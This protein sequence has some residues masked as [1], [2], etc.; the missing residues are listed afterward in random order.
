MVVHEYRKE[1][2]K[3]FFIETKRV[4]EKARLKEKLN[5]PLEQQP[6]ESFE[7]DEHNMFSHLGPMEPEGQWGSQALQW[8][9]E[10]P[11][12]FAKVFPSTHSPLTW[13]NGNKTKC[14]YCSPTNINAATEDSDLERYDPKERLGLRKYCPLCSSSLLSETER[15]EKQAGLGPKRSRSRSLSPS[16]FPETQIDFQLNQVEQVNLITLFVSKSKS[17]PKLNSNGNSIHDSM[18]TDVNNTQAPQ[19]TQNLPSSSSQSSKKMKTL[20][21]SNGHPIT[22]F[23]IIKENLNP[24]GSLQST[25][26]N[27]SNLEAKSESKTTIF[28]P[29]QWEEVSKN[30]KGIPKKPSHQTPSSF[31]IIS[32]LKK[33]Q[34]ETPTNSYP[35]E[36]DDDLFDEKDISKFSPGILLNTS[37]NSPDILLSDGSSPNSVPKSHSISPNASLGEKFS[38]IAFRKQ[39]IDPTATP[40]KSLITTALVSKKSTDK[41][42]KDNNNN[43]NTSSLNSSPILS[44]QQGAHTTTTTTSRWFKIKE[45]SPQKPTPPQEKQQQQRDSK[46][47]TPTSNKSELSEIEKQEQE[48]EQELK[49]VEEFQ[50]QENL[51]GL[52]I[53]ANERKSFIEFCRSFTDPFNKLKVW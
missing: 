44:S 14:P 28:S 30:M 43:N 9:F 45:K 1:D 6:Q 48:Q 15:K 21:N 36:Q 42:D 2:L 23:I 24:S 53:K 33:I 46:Q 3:E 13:P 19:T 16:N 26:S 38:R 49:G 4:G 41:D 8:Y 40:D 32:A 18:E 35:L 29:N 12:Y 10:Q 20:K 25:I 5:S 11:R 17:T 47:S 52:S 37:G 27:Y 31:S 7:H 22:E 39:T 34:D 50:E 51:E